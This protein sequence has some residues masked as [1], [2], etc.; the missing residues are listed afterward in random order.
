[1]NAK[2]QCMCEGPVRTKS[3]FTTMFHLDLMADDA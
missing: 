3:K 1:V 2:Q